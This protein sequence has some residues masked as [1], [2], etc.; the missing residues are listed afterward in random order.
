MYTTRIPNFIDENR[1][2]MAIKCKIH[3]GW[4]KRWQN[5]NTAQAE[6]RLTIQCD[7][8]LEL[9]PAVTLMSRLRNHGF[10]AHFPYV[11]NWI[12]P[13]ILTLFRCLLR[14]FPRQLCSILTPTLLRC[15]SAFSH[16]NFA[17]YSLRPYSD[18]TPHFPTPTSLYFAPTFPTFSYFLIH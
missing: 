4:V 7:T 8:V 6:A 12:F 13:S 11:M 16:A 18:V 14:I 1:L 17:P 5:F 9:L 10:I 2:E 15:Y 3:V